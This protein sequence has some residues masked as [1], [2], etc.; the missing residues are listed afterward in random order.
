MPYVLRNEIGEISSISAEGS[1][2]AVWLDEESSEWADFV[3]RH[4]IDRIA[5]A[6]AALSASDPELLR[7]V[8]DLITALIDKKVILYTD[9]PDPAQ[10][11]LAQRALMREQLQVLGNLMV[12][13]GDIL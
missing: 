2:G 7:V 11:K 13:E 3:T 4:G 10:R 6:K 9:L 1:Q 8:E 5:S 12:G